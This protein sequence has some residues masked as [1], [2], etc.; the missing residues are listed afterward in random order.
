MFI[1]DHMHTSRIQGV[2]RPN[3]TRFP[4]PAE[5]IAIMDE[6][7]IDMAVVLSTVNPECRYCF[8]IP[9][10]V[11]EICAEHPDRFIPFASVDPRMLKN[12]VESDYLPLLSYYKSVGC[13]GIGEY[14]PNLPFDD[15][16]NLNVFRQVGEAGL[17]LLFHIAPKIG[18][19]Y[20][21]YDECG[22]PRLENVLREC[23]HLTMLGHSQPFWS[24]ISSDLTKQTRTGY[25]SGP[26]TPGRVVEL[27][28]KY[29][30]LHGD[31]SAGSGFNA[32]TRDP[33]FG[34]RFLEEF[35][36]RLYFGSDICNPA[37]RPRLAPYL[38]ELKQKR[39]ISSEAYEKITWRNAA[40]LFNLRL[41]SSDAER[42]E[43]A[44]PA[45]PKAADAPSR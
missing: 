29:P 32:V 43:G 20:G 36:D 27:M 4:T 16:L 23:P 5:L 7:G 10:E 9:E 31:L 8:V 40:K 18:G 14:M 34:Y 3:G 30:N 12:S 1:D 41:R 38:R 26:V 19:C 13:K 22:L 6:S 11:L 24:E 45:L 44:Q 33:E 2:R 28:R 25:V 21:C 35:Q 15:P 42:S 17:P 39:L 37:Q